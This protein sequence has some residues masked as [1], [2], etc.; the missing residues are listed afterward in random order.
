[1]KEKEN[2]SESTKIIVS[3]V[4]KSDSIYNAQ[5]M[6]KVLQNSE[7]ALWLDDYDDIFSDFDP[8]YYSQ[9]S[10]SDD[11]LL[12]LIKAVKNRDKGI[13]ELRFLLAENLRSKSKEQIIIKRLHEY[14]INHYHLV[15]KDKKKV[16]K[17][18][19]IFIAVGIFTMLFAVYIQIFFLSKHILFNFILVLAEPAGW[20]LFWEG[21]NKAI[22]DT[23]KIKPNLDFYYK[24]S[25]S[26]I[27]FISY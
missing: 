24:M 14:F 8:R 15:V 3:P 7:V 13:F 21:L 2:L 20:F 25:K 6:K 19:A 27:K 17:R 9:R 16:I 23:D 4:E 10:L 26:K 18:A 12:E 11:F 1:M 5:H 22:Y